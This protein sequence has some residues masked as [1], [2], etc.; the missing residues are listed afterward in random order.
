MITLL[1][2]KLKISEGNMEELIDSLKT[3]NLPLAVKKAQ[4]EGIFTIL[5]ENRPLS[6]RPSLFIRMSTQKPIII[7]ILFY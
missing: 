4:I 7:H 2:D 6:C 5:K 1:E 3:L